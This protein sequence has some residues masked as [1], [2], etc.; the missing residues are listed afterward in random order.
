MENAL[1]LNQLAVNIVK[2]FITLF[3][4]LMESPTITCAGYN[5]LRSTYS[6]EDLAHPSEPT[7]NVIKD[8]SLF[9]VLIIKPTEMSV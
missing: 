1:T 2:V 4:V 7:A 6:A 5:V 3:V 9:V 8:M